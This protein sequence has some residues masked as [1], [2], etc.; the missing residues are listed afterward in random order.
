MNPLNRTIPLCLLCFALILGSCSKQETI[1]E[2]YNSKLVLN[3]RIEVGSAISS[4]HAHSLLG[5][6]QVDG[7]EDLDIII[8]T[9]EESIVLFEDT[10]N[11]GYYHGPEDFIVEAGEEYTLSTTYADNT[12]SAQTLTPPSMEVL[13]SS[14]TYLEADIQDDLIFLEWSNINSGS[15]N[16]YFYVLELTS[17]DADPIALVRV[18]SSEFK[19]TVVSYVS[20]AT[21][22]V[23]DFA[24][25]G[26]HKIKVYAVNKAYEHLFQSQQDFSTNGPSNIEGAFGYFIGSSAVETLIEIR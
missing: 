7:V 13:A 23:D 12:I 26:E 15:F 24:Y 2:Q 17:L 14:K 9:G 11:P 4:I 5:Q 18:A 22:S 6:G 1:E 8:S 21:L 10:R 19:S 25:Y 20:E 16:E 3:A